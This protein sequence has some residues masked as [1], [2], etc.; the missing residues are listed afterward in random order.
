MAARV[1]RRAVGS[2]ASSASPDRRRISSLPVR[3][4]CGL[5]YIKPVLDPVSG[6]RVGVVVAERV[7]SSSRGIRTVVSEGRPVMPTLVPVTVQPYDLRPAIPVLSSQS[8]IGQP[9]LIAHVSPEA[10]SGGPR[11]MARP[12]LGDRP[13]HSR[14]DPDRSMPPLLRWR[15]SFAE[16]D[17]PPQG[18]GVDR[19][20]CSWPRGSCCGSPRRE[21][22]T[23]QIF[24]TAALGA[25]LRALLRTPIDFLLTM[26]VSR[27]CWCSRSI[28][29][30]GCGAPSG[31]VSRRPMSRHDWA[32]LP[33]RRSAPARSSRC[34]SSDTRYC[35]ATRSPR[36]RSTRCIF[37][38]IRSSPLG[39]RSPSA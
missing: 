12:H 25:G 6:H 39:L 29:P 5:I 26:A 35:S 4:A 22:W 27:R 16:A 19:R 21:R 24:H 11:A 38:C 31:S 37:R 23:D 17:G 7:V 28:W 2:S 36:R 9:L 30:N 14:A 3:S 13:R 15:E 1:E 32:I 18:G 33:R 10:D 34:C 8:P 20:D